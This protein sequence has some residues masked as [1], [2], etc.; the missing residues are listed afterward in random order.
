MLFEY[1]DDQFQLRMTTPQKGTTIIKAKDRKNITKLL[2][3]AL[4][5]SHYQKWVSGNKSNFY[6]ATFKTCP[7]T[8]KLIFKGAIS[9]EAWRFIHRARTNTLSV[10]ARS[11]KAEDEKGLCRRCFQCGETMSHCIQNCLKNMP[12]ICERHDDVNQLVYDDL[13]DPDLI[14]GLNQTCNL[15]NCEIPATGKD[16]NKQR[17]DLV[18]R[19]VAKK[20]IHL[21]DIKCPIDTQQCFA[22]TRQRNEDNYTL[23]KA[24][25]EESC[26]DYHVELHTAIFGSL[27]TNPPET[28]RILKRVGIPAN[29]IQK[30]LNN[31]SISNIEMSARIF[32]YHTRGTLS[33]FKSRKILR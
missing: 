13:V 22:E 24:N 26:P 5:D 14:V 12:L 7:K 18:I 8:N 29:K 32:N 4:Q 19:N 21:V 9:S 20:T 15:I 23:F 31:C 25:L 17:V 33:A 3:K 30:L 2:H 27:G 1:E 10:R 6:A 16:P 11:C 28:K